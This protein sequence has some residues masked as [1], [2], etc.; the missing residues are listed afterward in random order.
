M[1]TSLDLIR[2]KIL[3]RSDLYSTQDSGSNVA[4]LQ[5]RQAFWENLLRDKTDINKQISEFEY[6]I[7]TGF[8]EHLKAKLINFFDKELSAIERRIYGI[9]LNKIPQNKNEFVRNAPHEY[10][11]LLNKR[12]LAATILFSARI[13]AYNSL[14]LL[15][16]ASPVEQLAKIFDSN[17]ESFQIFL[18]PLI[19]ATFA[20]LFGEEFAGRFHYDIQADPL[21]EGSFRDANDTTN[22]LGTASITTETSVVVPPSVIPA[23]AATPHTVAVPAN[24]EHSQATERT[25]ALEKLNRLW[26]LANGSL[27]LPVLIILVVCGFVIR[28]V[29]SSRNMQNEVLKP[30]IEHQM[31]LLKESEERHNH[32]ISDT[33]SY[34][35]MQSEIYKPLF[36]YQINLLK[37][38][39]KQIEGNAIQKDTD[40]GSTSVPTASVIPTRNRKPRRSSSP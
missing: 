9:E 4:A 19:P 38:I 7:I 24:M 8:G 5:R 2:V 1:P 32:L 13:K 21:V 16:G 28:E 25:R 40:D 22:A 27:I 31:K 33:T 14:E 35:K 23:A 12:L 11:I 20:E 37:V 17:F 6:K 30:L 26:M 36:E 34:Q 39:T 15:L 29:S 3:E 18:Q 10:Q